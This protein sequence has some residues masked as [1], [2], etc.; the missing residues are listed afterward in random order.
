MGLI[1]YLQHTQTVVCAKMLCGLE[2][3][4]DNSL[5]FMNRVLKDPRTALFLYLPCFSILKCSTMYT[6]IVALLFCNRTLIG[7]VMAIRFAVT[8]TWGWNHAS[9]W[10]IL[11][12][13]GNPKGDPSWW[14]YQWY[15]QRK[16]CGVY[17]VWHRQ[18]AAT[19]ASLSRG[20]NKA[21]NCFLYSYF[22][23]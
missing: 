23:I 15:R 5:N 11:K 21:S 22:E 18:N 9:L 12:T 3:F 8:N 10:A 16:L 7:P 17:T 6:H 4:T 20:S 13:I 14:M 1:R 19:F 2:R